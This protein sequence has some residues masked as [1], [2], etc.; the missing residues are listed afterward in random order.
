MRPSYRYNRK[1]V[2]YA[3][4]CISVAFF[5]NADERRWEGKEKRVTANECT[6]AN[7]WRWG[8]GQ[9]EKQLDFWKF[10]ASFCDC[11]GRSIQQRRV[12]K[13][14]FL[15]CA[16]SELSAVVCVRL[17]CVFAFLY[18][19]LLGNS[20]V[21]SCSDVPYSKESSVINYCNSNFILKTLFIEFDSINL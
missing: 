4:G 7:R 8:R 9:D 20:G 13:S 16:C 17:D 18:V 3:Q 2:S 6:I 10:I 19:S 11:G 14:A 5:E 15:C 21:P 1:L 12:S